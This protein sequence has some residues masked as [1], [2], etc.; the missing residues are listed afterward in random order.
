M[1]ESLDLKQLSSYLDMAIHAVTTPYP[2]YWP[3][4][5]LAPDQPKQ[6]CRE[7]FPVFHKSYDWHSCVHGFWSIARVLQLAPSAE[8]VDRGGSLLETELT[9]DKIAGEMKT[10]QRIEYRSFERPYGLAWVCKLA[11]ELIGVHQKQWFA[12]EPLARFA[13]D[14]VLD[15]HQRL[16]YPLQTGEHSQSAFGLALIKDF[17]VRVGDD[18]LVARL[19]KEIARL[20]AVKARSIIHAEPSGHDFLS[21]SLARAM[22][23]GE[24]LPQT[25][26]SAWLTDYIPEL[27]RQNDWLPVVSGYDSSDGKLSHL[28]GLNLSR[29][30]M[31][32]RI[33]AKLSAN[34]SRFNVLLRVAA[35]HSTT[36]HKAVTFEHFASSHWLA[37]FALLDLTDSMS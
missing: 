19:N 32:K 8:Q 33:A 37:S 23:V 1:R 31:L 36:G 18:S 13:A 28:I 26:F 20:Y 30:W 12:V 14:R 17:A 15:W 16:T 10:L 24:Y 6:S 27:G 34:D 7:L 29:S 25:D 5:E 21:P 2:Y 9:A 11:G 4:Y 3:A 35:A 22:V